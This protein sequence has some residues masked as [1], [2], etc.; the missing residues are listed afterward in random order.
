MLFIVDVHFKTLETE[1]R[2]IISNT[3]VILLNARD[4]SKIITLKFIRANVRFEHKTLT[5]KTHY[6]QLQFFKIHNCYLQLY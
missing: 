4:L 2:S 6:V 1:L 3:L 5:G